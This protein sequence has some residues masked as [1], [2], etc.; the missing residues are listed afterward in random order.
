MVFRVLFLVAGLRCVRHT[1]GIMQ[2]D[3]PATEIEIAEVLNAVNMAG[4]NN[5]AAQCRRLAFERDMLRQELKREPDMMSNAFTPERA[6]HE[7][8]KRR[9]LE[10]K[11]SE[12][13]ERQLPGDGKEVPWS[14]REILWSAF[15][16]GAECQ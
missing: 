15:H 16:A 1:G 7:L 12:W 2:I 8:Q 3:V 5:Q 10:S 14:L 13:L 6:E 4:F 9:E 11:F